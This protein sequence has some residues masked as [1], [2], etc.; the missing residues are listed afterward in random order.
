MLINDKR[1]VDGV[2]K[3]SICISFDN[4][5]LQLFVDDEFEVS[6]LDRELPAPD[7]L[8]PVDSPGPFD[9]PPVPWF[10]F[11]NGPFPCPESFRPSARARN[12]GENA[13]LNPRRKR[14]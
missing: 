10:P 3:A 13:N 9:L 2:G 4:E 14:L 5:V 12:W 6:I 7:G 11:P 8:L 1:T